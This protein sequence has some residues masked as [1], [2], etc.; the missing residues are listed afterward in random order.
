[1]SFVCTLSEY[2]EATQSWSHI[3]EALYM[4]P[5]YT[6]FGCTPEELCFCLVAWEGQALDNSF[7]EVICAGGVNPIGSSL[8]AELFRRLM[9]VERGKVYTTNKSLIKAVEDCRKN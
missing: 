9:L 3:G 2:F 4:T 8:S 7:S 1:M 6:T 5:Q